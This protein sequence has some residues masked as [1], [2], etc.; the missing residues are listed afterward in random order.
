MWPGGQLALREGVP[1]EKLVEE[2]FPMRHGSLIDPPNRFEPTHRE[3][4]LEHLEWDEEYLA[5]LD[6]RPVEYLTDASRSIISENDSPDIPF[7]YSLNPYR[8]CQHGCSYCY[9]RNTHEYLGFSA[10]LDFETKIVVK[11]DA[12]ELLREFLAR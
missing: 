1:S 8:G 9:A 11:H 7:R 5:G 2:F 12:P 3:A 10:G 6:T 4:D